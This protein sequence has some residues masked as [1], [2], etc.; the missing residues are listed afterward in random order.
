VSVPAAVAGDAQPPYAVRSAWIGTAENGR[1]V[2]V[3]NQPGEA[4]RIIA[5]GPRPNSVLT[6]S[7]SR[8]GR[9]V[10]YVFGDLNSDDPNAK[11]GVAVDGK[12]TW[13]LSAG[14]L[15]GDGFSLPTLTPDGR[16]VVMVKGRSAR[17]IN[18]ATGTSRAACPRCTLPPGVFDAS[19]SPDLRFVAI[20][21]L[22]EGSGLVRTMI[23]RRSDGA[24]VARSAA[25]PRSLDLPAHWSP[26]SREVA[27]TAALPASGGSQGDA[28]YTLAIG[29]REVK[30]AFVTA[31][32]PEGATFLKSPAYWNGSVIAQQV[33]VTETEIT[34]TGLT[35]MSWQRKPTAMRGAIASYERGSG[36]EELALIF[37][38]P[39]TSQQ[40]AELV[41]PVD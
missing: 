6:I 33:T 20:R 41:W 8:D 5:Q 2:A 12:I 18:V 14:G 19:F 25:L 23:L 24:V 32:V 38:S 4:P 30:T 10:I 9:A 13:S 29:G 21:A 15:L 31:S 17:M 35:S 37:P 1:V 39:W 3:A 11:I 28:V 36:P 7:A 16:F 22:A 26:D 27:F 34:I 40:P